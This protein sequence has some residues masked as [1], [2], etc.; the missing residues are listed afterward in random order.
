VL[1]RNPEWEPELAG[2]QV[3]SSWMVGDWDDVN[4][5]VTSTTAHTP[6][7]VMAKLLLSFRNNDEVVIQQSLTDARLALGAPISAAGARGY[8]QAHDAFLDLHLVHELE[9]I[10]G[11]VN[12]LNSSQASALNHLSIILDGRLEATL[13]VFRTR[14]RVMSLRRTAF[15]LKLVF[16]FFVRN[17]PDPSCS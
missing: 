4:S 3:E 5:I 11:S 15:Q 13:P 7:I 2:F 17:I 10:N 16:F 6:P 14:E 8:R 1:T 9:L 12:Q